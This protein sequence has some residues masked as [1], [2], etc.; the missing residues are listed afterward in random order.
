MAAED[1]G[2][3]VVEVTVREAGPGWQLSVTDP[4]RTLS[5]ELRSNAFVPFTPQRARGSG[6]GLAVV[7]RIAREHKGEA[8][9][10]EGPGGG[11]VI[12]VTFGS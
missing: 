8:R 3:G 10:D 1:V 5:A 9:I 6:L 12:T 4:G 7:A 11:N 2:G